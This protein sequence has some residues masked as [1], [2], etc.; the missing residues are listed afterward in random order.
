MDGALGPITFQGGLGTMSTFHSMSKTK[1]TVYVKHRIIQM[2]DLLES[3]GDEPIDLSIQMHFHA[4]YTMG[5][6]KA[7]TALESLMDAKIP[8]PLIIGATPVGRGFLTLFVIEDISTKM[9]KFSASSLIIGDIDVKLCEYA[10]ALSLSGP[11]S[12]LGG[13]LAG[14]ARS[15][16]SLTS[17]IGGNIGGLNITSTASQVFAL[18]SPVPLGS[19]VG[20]VQQTLSG[21]ALGNSISTT[22]SS[23]QPGAVT[24]IVAPTQ[25]MLNTAITN[26]RAAG[27]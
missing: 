2:I 11:L 4:P 18:G 19:S 5:P 15:V 7:L 27:H 22:L 1:K 16:G 26:L 6:G 17:A 10:G 24:Q 25:A 23:L 13:G 9:N 12:A 8:V 20:Q 14:L 21:A 3:T